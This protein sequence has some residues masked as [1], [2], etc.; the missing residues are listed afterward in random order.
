MTGVPRGSTHP[1][2]EDWGWFGP[3]SV[4]RRVNGEAALILA[5]PRMLLM[6]IAHPAVALAVARHSDFPHDAWPR[7]RR[8]LDVMFRMTFGDSEEASRSAAGLAAV[9]A[10]VAGAGYRALDQDLLLWV[11]ATLVDG[12]LEGY[13]RFVGGLDPAE[14]DAYVA[15]M[16]VLAVAS[17]VRE[18]R[19]PATKPAF[20]RYLAEMA[21]ELTVGDEARALA[22]AILSPPLPLPLIGARAF[23]RLL[24]VGMLPPPIRRAYGLGWSAVHRAAFEAA[25]PSVRLLVQATP[26]R[27]RRVPRG[28]VVHGEPAPS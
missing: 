16:G 9:H 15:E 7:L 18:G 28:F 3:D 27:L 26:G 23:Q 20:A 8:T 12:G 24:T 1:A 4:V 17:G 13:R 22:P 5:G 14:E 2:G 6:Q 21:T 11:W 19:A 25:A 10:R